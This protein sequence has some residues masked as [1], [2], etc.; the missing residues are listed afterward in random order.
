MGAG[1]EDFLSGNSQVPRAYSSASFSSVPRKNQT[2]APAGMP[3]K[4]DPE[5]KPVTAMKK[6]E[7]LAMATVLKGVS[8]SRRRR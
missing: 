7:A 1:G 8:C 5:G 6:Q 3:K 2:K 4:G